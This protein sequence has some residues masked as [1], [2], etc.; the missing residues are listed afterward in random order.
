MV[1]QYDA[2]GGMSKKLIVEA[3][4]PA[5]NV[6]ISPIEKLP[7]QEVVLLRSNLLRGC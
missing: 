5:D 7:S 1:I 3:S 4:H 2:L 6:I